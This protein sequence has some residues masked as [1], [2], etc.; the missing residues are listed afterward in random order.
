MKMKKIINGHLVYGHKGQSKY[1]IDSVDGHDINRCNIGGYLV[2]YILRFDTRK[3]ALRYLLTTPK[4]KVNTV[5][6]PIKESMRK[7]ETI[8]D[9]LKVQTAYF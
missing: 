2:D 4:T 7:A 5:L 3:N 9:L 8:D 6:S 1:T